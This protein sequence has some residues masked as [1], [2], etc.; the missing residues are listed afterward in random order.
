[1]TG[2][3]RTGR[4]LEVWAKAHPGEPMTCAIGGGAA[5]HGD[6]IVPKSLGGADDADNLR[7][8]CGLHNTKRQNGLFSDEELRQWPCRSLGLTREEELRPLAEPLG[9]ELLPFE[10]P[11]Y[12][13]VDMPLIWQIPARRLLLFI[14]FRF[15]A[16]HNSKQQLAKALRSGARRHALAHGWKILHIHAGGITRF[17]DL[18]RESIAAFVRNPEANDFAVLGPRQICETDDAWSEHQPVDFG[19]VGHAILRA[20]DTHPFWYEME[21]RRVDRLPDGP[22]LRLREDFEVWERPTGRKDYPGERRR[23]AVAFENATE[24]SRG[25]RSLRPTT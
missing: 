13:G 12:V 23:F 3:K 17:D 4:Y 5:E 1:M 24:R 10:V 15:S 16:N 9:F 2:T 11:G 21:K 20:H 19:V 18:V 22:H 7:P 8:L 14:A 25:K 6:H